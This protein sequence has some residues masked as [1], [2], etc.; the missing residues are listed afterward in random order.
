MKFKSNANFNKEPKTGSIFTL[1]DNSLGIS[2]HKYVG[3]GDAL[4]LNSKALNIDN[5]DLGTE[6]FKE[7][8]SKTKEVVMREVKKIREDAYRFYS[9]NNI[10]FDRY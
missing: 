3:C 8:V 9:D 5:Y 2:I 10:E 7:A 4:F 1:E 6:D